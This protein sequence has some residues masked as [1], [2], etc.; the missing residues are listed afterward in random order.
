MKL[1]HYITIINFCSC[2]IVWLIKS[3]AFSQ[4]MFIGG[5]QGEFFYLIQGSTIGSEH[6]GVFA[7]P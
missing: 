4:K 3:N 7:F 6:K 2:I 1:F 5:A